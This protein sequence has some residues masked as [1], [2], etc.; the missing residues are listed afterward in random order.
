MT[1]LK[2]RFY[3]WFLDHK[4]S[5]FLILFVTF[6]FFYPIW[7]QGKVA[8][9][10]DALVG[11]HIP[12]VEK[13]WEGYPTGVPIKN[14]EI[15]DSISQFFPWRSLVGEFW[16]EAKAPLWNP[17]MFSGTPFLATLHSAALYPLNAIYLFLDNISAW[18]LIVFLQVFL[19]ALFMY[20][21]LQELGLSKTASLFASIAFCLSGYMIAWL[22]FATGGQ[23]GLWLPLLLLLETK[24]I[25]TNS[26][27]YLLPISV[28]FFFVFTAGDF[29]VPLYISLIYLFFGLY[30]LPQKN[31]LSLLFK[32]FTGFVGGVFLSSIQ[33]IPTIE[34]F[35][36]SIR[37]EDPYIKEYFYGLMHWEKV[38]NFIWPDFFGNV[39]TGN[40]WGKFGHHEY[41]GFAGVTTLV[42]V[43]FGLFTKKSKNENFFWYVLVVSLLF[44]FPTPLGFLPFK[45]KIPAL[46][47]SSASRLLFVIDFCL[48]I[49]AA[50]GLSKIT[51]LSF[52]KL[53]KTTFFYIVIS[54][55]TMVL[56]ILSIALFPHFSTNLKVA[57]KNTI[58]SFLVFIGLLA[59]V[60]VVKFFKNK[61]ILVGFVFLAFCVAEMFRFGWKNISF[62]PREFVFP[63]TQTIEFLKSSV[64]NQRISGGI[65]LNLNVPYKIPSAE[66]YDPIYPMINGHWYSIVNFSST[67][68][69][70]RRYGIIHY[71]DSLMINYA[72][73]KYV[74]DYKK[75]DS[76]YLTEDGK[77][78]RGIESEKFKE[79]FSEGRVK[80]FE[81]K[82]AL[83]KVWM[84]RDVKFLDNQDKGFVD[85][86][87]DF[88]DNKDL[89]IL[90]PNTSFLTTTDPFRYTLEEFS[91]N[92]N[93]IDIVANT[94]EDA[95]L[96]LSETF[97]NGWR[98]FVD[99]KSTLIY[100]ANFA[101][102][103]IQ[104][105]SGKHKIQFIY[106]P[107]SYTIG[108]I[109]SLSTL[110][111]L[112]IG[113]GYSYKKAQT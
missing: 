113:Y 23:A 10:V 1:L 106:Q 75:N 37:M 51:K 54:V 112:V 7:L 45:L 43:T 100:R 109:I 90:S 65:P 27:R 3:S 35:S 2:K 38:A 30:F 108:E 52:P 5:L 42:L 39:V 26:V 56:L 73:I 88:K 18:N 49:L 110:I 12:W 24:L 86:V 16:R 29:Q 20:L 6:I 47:T 92:K 89:I 21:F 48:A 107:L 82:E 55:I 76:G 74:V 103:A 85:N 66:G 53:V 46:G 57:L 58:P 111:I 93:K 64:G 91:Q 50:F 104:V 22:E 95:F 8:L 31:R 87:P 14:L 63:T 4:L 34:L 71:Y 79:V 67:K 72:A 62:S 84:S 81:N 44:L 13:T 99:G 68:F 105:P 41:L 94:E 101:F 11:A 17:Y 78:S 9:P 60:I 96:F 59:G 102:Q 77:Y 61:T 33:L 83:P 40:Y 15:T 32:I 98:A 28:V 97:Y 19:S 69:P 36:N 80:V 25:K 70:S